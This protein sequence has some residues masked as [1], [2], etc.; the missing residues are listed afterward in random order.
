MADMLALDETPAPE[1]GEIISEYSKSHEK[2]IESIIAT[3]KNYAPVYFIDVLTQ[4]D[5]FRVNVVHRKYVVRKTCPLPTWNSEVYSYHNKSDQLRIEWVIPSEQDS[6]NILR[7]E[8]INDTS[9]VSWIK[10]MRD[11]TLKVPPYSP[12]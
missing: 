6:M 11:G 9:L 3:H 10:G 2:M 7:N 4:K 12:E 8:S 5:P 1:A